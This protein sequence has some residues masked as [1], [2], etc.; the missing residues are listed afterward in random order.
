MSVAQIAGMF[1]GLKGAPGY[2][3]ERILSRST[4]FMPGHNERALQKA[5]DGSGA[6]GEA[7]VY[8]FDLEDGVPTKDAKLA[9]RN[10]VIDLLRGTD[11]GKPIIVRINDTHP[12]T[13]DG[14]GLD[15]LVAL[16]SEIPDKL[17][18]FMVPKIVDS[19]HARVIRK[20][21]R[22]LCPNANAR[23]L[24]HF[25]FEEAK[26]TLNLNAI[27]STDGLYA[28]SIGPADL[29]GSCGY[30]FPFVGGGISEFRVMAPM[31]HDLSADQDREVGLS[32]FWDVFV[33]LASVACRS[34]GVY[35]YFG[36]YTDLKDL[37]GFRQQCVNA[38]ARAA[39]GIWCLHPEQVPIANE[40]FCPSAEQVK[41]A[42]QI[43]TEL[44]KP[45][46]NMMIGGRFQDAATVRIYL[47]VIARAKLIAQGDSKMADTYKAVGLEW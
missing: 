33:W 40:A 11:L 27:A 4:L 12:E 46:P 6:V 21:V 34:N 8:C 5:V 31:N 29:A 38:Y 28:M 45:E 17:H 32:E 15:D 42:Q 18:Q 41:L 16:C 20:A 7:D 23:P 37:R 1:E 26:A 36:P 47:N 19:E 14:T 10:N 39:E 30:E 3:G 44:K 9:A 43:V 22:H 24:V 25:I 2:S 13:G 35:F